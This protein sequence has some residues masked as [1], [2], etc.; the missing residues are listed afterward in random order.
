M[1]LLKEATGPL[2]QFFGYKP[3]ADGEPTYLTANVEALAK[4]V[5]KEDGPTIEIN[6]DVDV[7]LREV[8]GG[9]GHYA[10]MQLTCDLI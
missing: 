6:N 10:A 5:A 4:A 1:N 9:M 2:M 7:S 3:Q 8:R